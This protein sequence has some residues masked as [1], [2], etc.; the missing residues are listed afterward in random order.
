MDQRKVLKEY[1]DSIGTV[2]SLLTEEG[3]R[4]AILNEVNH[5]SNGR[6]KS[7]LTGT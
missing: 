3:R 6:R 4:Q 7:G 1:A 2:V 5:F